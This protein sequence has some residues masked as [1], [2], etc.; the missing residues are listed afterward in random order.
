MEWCILQGAKQGLTSAASLQPATGPRPPPPPPLAAPGGPAGRLGRRLQRNT[1]AIVSGTCVP[2][3]APNARTPPYLQG[4]SRGRE[5]P[6]SRSPR[7]NPRTLNLRASAHNKEVMVAPSVF[8]GGQLCFWVAK[9]GVAASLGQPLLAKHE[10]DDQNVG[11]AAYTSVF[12]HSL[13]I[14]CLGNTLLICVPHSALVRRGT[15]F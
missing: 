9:T 5:R 10:N 4:R 2:N 1:T 15:W 13:L 12:S 11:L 8:I 6:T 7:I 3:S 14:R